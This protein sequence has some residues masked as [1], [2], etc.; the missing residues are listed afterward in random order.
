MEED[1]L[2]FSDA[3]EKA[4]KMI[5]YTNHTLVAAGNPSY[6]LDTVKWW[7]QT[8]AERLRV[9]PYEIVKAG[10]VNGNSFSITDFALNI[11]TKQSAVSQVHAEYAKKQYPQY[12]WVGITNG[13]HTHRWQ[14]SDFRDVGIN[15]HD[16]WELHLAKKRELVETVVKRTG[17]GYDPNK[18]VI[19]WARRLAEYKQPTAIFSDITRLKNIVTNSQRP[20]QILFA[21]NSHSEDPNARRLIEELINLFSTEL[22][23]SA[24]FI[25]NYNISLANHLTSGSDI[26]L[27]TPK[28]NL[29][30]CGTSGM[31]AISNGVLNCTVIDGWTYEVDWQGIGW[32][33]D[34]N[35][36]SGSFYD[37]LE[38]EIA[39][40]Y[41]TRNEEELPV[42]WISRM[43]KSIELSK[44]FSGVRMLK[45]YER[46][47]YE[48]SS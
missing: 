47:L 16:L 30:A 21:G 17:F 32:T 19:T 44:Q 4:K 24:I 2:T 20:V 27:N 18:L 33:L 39:P 36:V 43:R 42:E 35:N 23:G 34:P 26:W 41:F 37:I 48:R 11:S 14:D 31:K 12:N 9:D 1:R 5:V 8:M 15:D 3:W 45:D 22:S 38:K 28:G 13:V 46:L 10:I 29:E 40:M 7:G 25:P 6:P